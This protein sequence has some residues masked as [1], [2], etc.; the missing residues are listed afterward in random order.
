MIVSRIL[1]IASLIVLCFHL[2]PSM[3]QS[4]TYTEET[5]T[6]ECKNYTSLNNVNI[7][8]SGK[9]RELILR[10][11][12]ERPHSFGDEL[13]IF[14]NKIKSDF[15]DGYNVLLEN[16]IDFDIGFNPFNLIYESSGQALGDKLI[17]DRSIL[18]F[19][20]NGIDVNC[21]S[22]VSSTQ[23]KMFA[24]FKE[25]HFAAN[26]LYREGQCPI[27]FGDAELNLVR[28][29]GVDYAENVFSFA[30]FNNAT[31]YRSNV[32]RVVIEEANLRTL[33]S[34][35]LNV[36]V[37]KNAKEIEYYSGLRAP[38]LLEIE[39]NLFF[40]FRDL[41]RLY[42]SVFD[43]ERFALSSTGTWMSALNQT[44]ADFQLNLI[45]NFLTKSNFSQKGVVKTWL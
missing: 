30:T 14:F 1:S 6:L 38:G 34:S 17:I 33:G 27:I 29:A 15:E 25:V 16:F 28:I 7:V 20:N 36:D 42:I 26:T 10:P 4:C 19:K 22:Y 11:I 3:S 32:D 24:M 21:M 44:K 18:E 43:F 31:V 45:G 12:L 37:F 13:I 8:L 39:D 35:I 41:S 5:K 2:S 23:K 40:S 9:I